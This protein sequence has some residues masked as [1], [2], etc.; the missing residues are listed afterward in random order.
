MDGRGGF[1]SDCKDCAAKQQRE[2]RKHMKHDTPE[3]L[4]CARCGRTLPISKFAK[5]ATKV[6]GHKSHCKEC[7]ALS[8][9]WRNRKKLL[10]NPASKL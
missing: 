6:S 2:I 7:N 9:R 5:D 8:R 4:T 3:V 10:N 1:R